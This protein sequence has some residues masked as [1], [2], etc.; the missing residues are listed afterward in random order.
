M[1]Q[2]PPGFVLD[3][4]P[5]TSPQAVSGLP[6]G[7][8]LDDDSPPDIT[9]PGGM[10]FAE[11]QFAQQPAA[12]QA[13]QQRMLNLA[14][15]YRQAPPGRGMAVDRRAQAMAADT[16]NNNPYLNATMQGMTVGL[17]DEMGAGV[18]TGLGQ[19]DYG[20]NLAVEREV[21]N[22]QRQERPWG[23]LGAEIVGG[24]IPALLTGGV[25]VAARVAP[26][27]PAW[28]ARTADAAINGG[29]WGG[30]Y[31]A[32]TGEGVE[33]RLQGAG[34]G[35][36]I[37]AGA[38]AVAQ[39]VIEGTIAAGRAAV[40]AVG[41]YIAPFSQ[42]G[43]E[44]MAATTLR[45]A[46]TDPVAARA[47][48]EN[49]NQNV[50]IV[51][52]SR[53]TTFQETGDMGLGALERRAET[54]N[55]VPFQQR[56]ADQNAARVGM[57]EGVQ[58]KGQPE[59]VV[60]TLRQNL[61]DI[62]RVTS[63]ALEAATA[64]ARGQSAA[65]GGAGTPEGYGAAMRQQLD[66]ARQA[67]KVRENALWSAVDPDG[68]LAA[69]AAG[70]RNAVVSVMR[71]LPKA[72]KPMAGE[73][74]AIFIEA[75]KFNG[76]TPFKE[77]AALR[78]RLNDA[79]RDELS[80]H[81]QSQVYRRM[82]QLRG[83]VEDVLDGS[84]ATKAAQEAQAV[85]SGAMREEDTMAA[86]L[87]QGVQ[88]WYDRRAAEAGMG[89]TVGAGSQG[90]A[91]GGSSRVS[92]APGAASQSG[93]GSRGS[94]GNPGV[95]GEGAIPPSFDPEAYG[96]LRA[97]SAATKAR[98]QTYDEGIVGD[99]LA[100]SGSQGP[101]H[102]PAAAVPEKLFRRGAMGAEGMRALQQAA[103]SPETMATMRDYA[104]SNLRK[105]AER[106]DGTLDPSK[107]TIWRKAHA[108]ALRSMPEID[109]MVAGPVEA[110]ETMGR[111]AVE[112][113]ATMDEFRAGAIGR[114]IDAAP[115]D[116]TRKLGAVFSTQD[117]TRTMRQ[118]ETATRGNP[119]AR[120]G[121]RQGI[122]DWITEHFISNTEAGTSGMGQVKSDQ[123]QTFMKQ[124]AAALGVIFK[125]GEVSALKALAADLQQANRSISAVKLPGRSNTPQDIIAEA[126]G[127]AVGQSWLS[128]L[129]RFGTVGTQAGVGAI[130]GGP[131][132]AG[133]AVGAGEV[134]S[135]L[136]AAGVQKVDDIIADAMLNPGRA[137]ILLSK[138]PARPT[139]KDIET[140][141]QRYRKA[142]F[143]SVLAVLNGERERSQ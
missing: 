24:A 104:V 82:T 43:R 10:G 103:N 31:C 29:L 16:Q 68:T 47:A 18:R 20:E 108:D 135:V 141:A 45:D 107:V 74:R 62:D 131:V 37:G 2:L 58:P 88:A 75:A 85:A 98:A 53:P 3:D 15:A 4:A 93:T 114:L 140:F 41:D 92:S 119:E 137:L 70:I 142:V 115:E 33:G 39:P 49:P 127:G 30:A 11:Q 94:A 17:A 64:N 21:L 105:F 101:F 56:R 111:L 96:R 95:Q 23:M 139:Q 79:M 5:A 60:N 65:L 14:S 36:L 35:A 6:A 71:E 72:A 143:P 63:E 1:S 83:A 123:F 59:A 122:A 50:P 76:V 110:S 97:A 67:A 8:V 77:I 25:S 9:A 34:E 61:A 73:E 125:P 81:G 26:Q 117:A 22:R 69:D 38:G 130:A 80:E 118:L 109:R 54:Q 48:L 28:L 84:V 66:Q 40:N 7:F 90:Y 55:A 113:K 78:T 112:R 51:P 89:Q 134:L 120:E 13:D 126:R 106:A 19:G 102:V 136:R 44:S 124:N 132:G 121:L 52:G 129:A 32:G 87:S 99:V 42:T 133:V 138:A 12:S 57:L 91:P 46:A 100:R 27:A 86:R 116:V 128:R